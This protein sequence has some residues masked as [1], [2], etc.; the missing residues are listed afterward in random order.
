MQ[1]FNNKILAVT[2]LIISINTA[3]ASE[4]LAQNNKVSIPQSV[5]G[6]TDIKTEISYT[7]ALLELEKAKYQ[8]SRAKSGIFDDS[9][10]PQSQSAMPGMYNPA[11][12]VLSKA[13]D[14]AASVSVNAESK[15]P[16]L[17]AVY[18]GAKL[19]ALFKFSDGSSVEARAGDTL[20]GGYVVKSV[21]VD[22]VQ[23]VHEGKVINVGS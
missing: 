13:N 5:L 14:N 22:R 9:Q 7:K 12:S 23:L 3:S 17:A 4:D 8:L 19:T 20:P 18:G 2:L 6:I 10:T 11:P 21:T 16:R 1:N 15:T